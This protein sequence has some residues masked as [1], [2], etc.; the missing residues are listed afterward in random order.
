VELSYETHAASP[1]SPQSDCADTPDWE[2]SWP[3]VMLPNRYF[4]TSS[5]FRAAFFAPAFDFFTSA[6]HM[7]ASLGLPFGCAAYT[8]V[9]S[10]LGE[11]H[12]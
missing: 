9:P 5:K 6:T 11:R 2:T 3:L 12:E 7:N 1:S 8:T 10:G 4:A